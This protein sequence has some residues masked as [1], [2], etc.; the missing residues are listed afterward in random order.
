MDAILLINVSQGKMPRARWPRE[1][2]KSNIL[3]RKASIVFDE[4]KCSNQERFLYRRWIFNMI[5]SAG[6]FYIVYGKEISK[7][8]TSFFK[9]Q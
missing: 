3:E 5:L 8:E 9:I 1:E 7:T 6:C 2:R 4:R